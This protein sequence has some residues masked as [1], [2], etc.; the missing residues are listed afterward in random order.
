VE[1]ALRCKRGTGG[2][3]VNCHCVAVVKSFRVHG[4][5]VAAG[6]ASRV[7]RADIGGTKQF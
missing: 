1:M 2:V 5:S 3:A 7:T 4:A 6:P